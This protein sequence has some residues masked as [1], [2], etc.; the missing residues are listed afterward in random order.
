MSDLIDRQKLAEVSALL[1]LEAVLDGEP[2]SY[3]D[4][5]T[6]VYNLICQLPSAQPDFD[7]VEKIDLERRTDE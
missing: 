2:K 3:S 5:L 4:G 6:K 7:T 1:L